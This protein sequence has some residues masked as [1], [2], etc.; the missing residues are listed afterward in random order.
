MRIE[1]H[2]GEPAGTGELLGGISPPRW[3]N[4]AQL[5]V[6]SGSTST[7]GLGLLSTV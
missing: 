3:A 6:A 2:G 4:A 5:A 1:V 7:Q